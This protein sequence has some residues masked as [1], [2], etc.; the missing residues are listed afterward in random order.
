MTH[1]NFRRTT[2]QHHN[3]T[4]KIIEHYQ[5]CIDDRPLVFRP[6][7]EVQKRSNDTYGYWIILHGK[8]YECT[9]GMC[10]G[11]LIPRT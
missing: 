10:M 1:H 2:S 9:S 6:L 11:I 8:I 3:I 5:P 7:T 4:T